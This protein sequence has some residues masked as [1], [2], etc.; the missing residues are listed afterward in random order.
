[1]PETLC[2]L[3]VSAGLAVCRRRSLPR[4]LP[5]PLRARRAAPRRPPPRRPRQRAAR[6]WAQ[7]G[8]GF[9]T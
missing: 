4:R 3:N 8:R 1:L 9:A 2:S 6:R 5:P 7:M